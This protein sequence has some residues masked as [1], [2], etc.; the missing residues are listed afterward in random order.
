MYIHRRKVC[1]CVAMVTLQIAY[2]N[3][4]YLPVHSVGIYMIRL[5]TYIEPQ[6]SHCLH[7]LH[8]PVVGPVT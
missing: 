6:T 4:Q 7:L 5:M 3:R 8:F 2:C 1:V